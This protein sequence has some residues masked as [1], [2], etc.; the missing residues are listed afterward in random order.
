MT[1]RNKVLLV[2]SIILALLV[3]ASVVV[4][5]INGQSNGEKIPMVVFAV[6]ILISVLSVFVVYFSKIQKRKYEKLLNQEYYEQYEIIKDAVANSQL[7]AST[8]KDIIEDILEIL[9]SAQESGK[10]VREVIEN[11]D[12]FANE[13]IQSFAMPFRLAMLNLYDSLIAF[14]LM[15]VGASLLLWLEQT[16]QNFFTT[17]LDISMTVFF[18][19]VA[20]VLLPVTKIGAGKRNPWIFIVPV[21]GGVL[22]VLMV[23]LLRAFFYEVQ[24]VQHFLDGTLRMVPNSMILLIYSLAI[25]LFLM[26]KRISRKYLLCGY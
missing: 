6:I 1:N 24:A 11:T 17:E 5:Q 14:I 22:F 23:E 2:S 20:F 25:P 7:S 13:I 19:L 15:V 18:L 8:K 16:Q 4:W 26:L 12:M 3:I 9:L 21:A 10:N